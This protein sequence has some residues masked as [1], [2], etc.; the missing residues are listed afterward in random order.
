MKNIEFFKSKK[1]QLTIVIAFFGL[2]SCS[3][4]ATREIVN[5]TP[6]APNILLII[7]DDMGK[8]ATNGFSEGT[9]KPKT[10]NID[11]FR[12][13]GISFNNFW[14]YPTCSPTRATI[15]T[16]KYGYTTGVKWAGDELSL[17]E[18]S[19]QKY[20]NEE[21][22]N[23]YATALVGKWHLS[24]NNSTFNPETFGIDYYAG[25]MRG[26]AQ[27]YYNWS[28]TEDGK[29]TLVTDY[30]TTKFTDLAVNWIQQQSKPWFLWLAYNAPHTPFHVPPSEMHSQ[31]NLAP[32]SDGM[33]PTPYYMAAIEAMDFQIGRLLQSMSE[34][35][36][37]NTIIIFIGDNGTPSEVA[38]SPFS[39]TSSKGSLYQGG[40]NVPMFITGNGVTRTGTDY[41][42]VSSTDLFATIAQIAG[43]SA[44]QINDSKSFKAL[45]SQ[46]YTFKNF[47]Y[48]EMNSGLKDAWT[49]SD[50][51][52]K[53]IENANGNQELYD[54]INDPYEQI[55]ILNRT[56]STTEANAKIAL[57]KELQTIRK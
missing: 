34:L 9:I 19:L 32:F 36:R 29:S 15:L 35:E 10:P 1:S 40:I 7:A 30:A 33:D 38:Q 11:S 6:N 3:K 49:V 2:M 21:T 25:L 17:S 42:L 46:P 16:G 4:D 22:N 47:Q 18:N 26:E 24:G 27:S 23:T 50:G 44:S 51:T 20:I 52:Y 13:N 12:N 28:L 43:V 8:D 48:S 54:L 41:N 55:N 57:E 14:T 53:M 31:G 56:L 45:L 39:K 5:T 37:A